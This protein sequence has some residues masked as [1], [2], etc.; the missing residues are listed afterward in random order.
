M[1]YPSVI[2][3]FP[4]PTASSKLNNPSHSALENLQSSTIGQ[5]ETIIGLSGDSSIL[6]TIIGDL[7]SPDSNGGGHVQ[8]AN[9]G[10]TGQTVYNK[11]DLLI[12][13]N[14]SSLGRLAVG[15]DNSQLL[16]DST[17]PVGIRWA[18]SSSP[19]IAISG[20]VVAYTSST[21]LN[22]TS[23]INTTVTASTLS[24]N[25]AI[26]GKIFV[27]GFSANSGTP[28]FIFKTI[29]GNTVFS[30]ITVGSIT[31]GINGS[32]AGDINF[33][34][35][36]SNSQTA[37]SGIMMS[38]LF[39]KRLPYSSNSSFVGMSIFVP[40]NLTEDS[41]ANKTLGMTVQAVGLVASTDTALTVRGWTIDKIS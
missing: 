8:T 14:S 2:T 29:Y 23:I 12:G 19:K 5:I 1:P 17:Q 3:T 9:K 37:Q 34:L 20:S 10:G 7:R 31:A 38:H 13:V 27:D 4:Q 24:T 25:N 30:S 22:E 41:G 39:S 11:G 16:A 35:I 28:A 21:I 32:V 6:G 40:A 26:R 33:E 18:S 36:S 15:P